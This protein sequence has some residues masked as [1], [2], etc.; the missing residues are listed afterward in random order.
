MTAR[1]L[2]MPWASG[3]RAY[4]LPGS[5]TVK[6]A[7]GEA[8]ESIPAGADVRCRQAEAARSMDGGVVDRIVRRHAGAMRLT[9]LHPAAASLG[10]PG[11]R[12]LQYSDR[13]QVFGL[14]R[15]FRLEVPVGTPIG[16]LVDALNQVATVEAAMANYVCVVPSEVEPLDS[17]ENVG[18][19]WERIRAAE[20][21]AYCC[22]DPAVVIAVVDSGVAP[23]HP[24]LQGK[25][26]AGYDT[27][28][29]GQSDLAL[30]IQLVG[31][32]SQLDRDP[33]DRHV[34]HG[35]GCMGIIGARGISMPAGLAGDAQILPLRALGAAI[36]PGKSQAM[37]I[38]A[39]ADLDMAMK[40]GVDLG[41]KVFNMSFGTDDA[42]LPPGGPRPHEDVVAYALDRGCILVA[43]SGNGGGENRYWPAAFPGV[44]AVGSVD[45][46]GRPS[47]FSTRG[48]HVALC[49]P[50]EH[51]RTLGLTG[52]QYATGTSFAAPFVAA[53]TA[54]MVA[55]AQ[56][57]AMPLEGDMVRQLLMES[58]QPFSGGATSGCG[59]GVLDALAALQALDKYIDRT[60][61]DDPGH[62]EEG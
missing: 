13:E 29:L 33:L 27:V 4:C 20:A 41:G 57:R 34:G 26:R 19:P 6:M 52:Y 36:F 48:D 37:G 47:R 35:M 39:S 5:L 49:A 61:P 46:S 60:Q 8:P 14:A 62:V 11:A 18:A 42:T 30:G 45:S 56:A 54:L 28:Q 31:D 32:R 40:L 55:R 59:A 58:A 15:T 43:A 3:G 17:S 38:G 21:L 22:G 12:H 53:T 1:Q 23:D 44:I 51:V 50:G 2:S 10:R 16:P 25:L 24:E 9:R 7:L